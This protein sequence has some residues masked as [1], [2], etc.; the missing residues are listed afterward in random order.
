V[1][2]LVAAITHLG[3]ACDDDVADDRGADDDIGGT[4]LLL[5]FP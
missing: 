4:A 2:A 3:L 5:L 1:L